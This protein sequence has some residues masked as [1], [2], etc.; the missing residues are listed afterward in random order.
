M[1][2]SSFLT[3]LPISRVQAFQEKASVTCSEWNKVAKGVPVNVCSIFILA[4]LKEGKRGRH[5]KERDKY[6]KIK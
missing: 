3:G 5:K 1:K 2:Y 4:K 6:L